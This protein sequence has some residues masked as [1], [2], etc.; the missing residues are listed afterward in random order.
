MH[1]SILSSVRPH[2]SVCLHSPLLHLAQGRPCVRFRTM[3]TTR[4][5]ES[6]GCQSLLLC[7]LCVFVCV[8]VCVCVS[9]RCIEGTS[10]RNPEPLSSWGKVESLLPDT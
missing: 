2:M 7:A 3:T 8:C 4:A 1:L 10:F 9:D 6:G 5:G